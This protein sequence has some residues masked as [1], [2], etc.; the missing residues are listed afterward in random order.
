MKDE[1]DLEQMEKEREVRPEDGSEETDRKARRNYLQIF[2][3]TCAV[4]LFLYIIFQFAHFLETPDKVQ[5]GKIQVTGEGRE[6]P[7]REPKSAPET[8]TDV[9][10]EAET[11]P[12]TEPITAVE[13]QSDTPENETDWQDQIFGEKVDGI[14]YHLQINGLTQ[15]QREE[16]GFRESDFVKAAGQFL[17]AHDVRTTGVTFGEAAEMSGSGTTYLAD[18]DGYKDKK[19]CVMMYADYPGEYILALIDVPVE[20]IIQ[21]ERVPS[22]PSTPQI[23]TEAPQPAQT[24]A[25]DTYNAADLN[26]TGIPKKLQNYIANEYE[27][28][29]SLYD[30]LYRHGKQEVTSATVSDYEIDADNRQATISFLLSDSGNITGTYRKDENS[31][32]YR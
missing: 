5:T 24:E 6:L 10:T 2:L 29:Y 11:K 15:A 30:Y 28:Q 21:T 23:Q 26:I 17:L 3:F 4:V 8:E 18:L 14:T 32:T 7:E 1:K 31:Y 22:L 25:Q 20:T 19:L 13:P 27:M 16:I 12:Q 9:V